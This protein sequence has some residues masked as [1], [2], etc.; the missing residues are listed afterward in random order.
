[1]SN[2]IVEMWEDDTLGKIIVIGFGLIILFLGAITRLLVYNW[3]D[4]NSVTKQ[5]SVALVLN[6]KHIPAHTS[7]ISNGKGATTPIYHPANWSI[8]LSFQDMEESLTVRERLYDAVNKNDQVDV[9][10]SI[11]RFSRKPRLGGLVYENHTRKRF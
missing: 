8:N 3:A 4:T 11:G 1:M 9:Y 10:Y 5:V 2:F 7:Y 6:K